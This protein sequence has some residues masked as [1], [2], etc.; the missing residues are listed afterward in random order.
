MYEGPEQDLHG[1][2]KESWQMRPG[3]INS[4]S[5]TEIQ[6]SWLLCGI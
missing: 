6:G 2:D 4:H 1:L 5:R 3:E